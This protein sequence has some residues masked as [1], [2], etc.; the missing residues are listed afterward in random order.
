M[1]A[2]IGMTRV[3]SLRVAQ[4]LKEDVGKNI[5]RLNSKIRKRL[6][7]GL[8]DA[9][10][11]RSEIGIWTSIVKESKKRDVDKQIIRLDKELRDMLGVKISET[12]NVINY[13]DFK[14]EEDHLTPEPLLKRDQKSFPSISIGTYVDERNK[15]QDSV[16]QRSKIEGGGKIED[17]VVQ[18]SSV[19]GKGQQQSFKFCPGCGIEF[20]VEY[21][22]CP[23]CGYN[24]RGE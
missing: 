6:G 24:I 5:V 21:T 19:T 23:G 12:L 4:G 22:F 13:L 7:L 15:I 9:V 1:G 2:V 17:S 20:T 8:Y 14:L 18:R 16:I 10:V 3:A 11:I